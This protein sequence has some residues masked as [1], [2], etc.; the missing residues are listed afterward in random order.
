[1]LT[2]NP[3]VKYVGCRNTQEDLM[4]VV[5]ERPGQKPYSL[6]WR[7]DI[8]NHSP[9]GIGWGYP[10]SGAA[11]CAVAI[12]ADYFSDGENPKFQKRQWDDRSPDGPNE[13]ALQFYMDFKWAYISRLKMDEGF[14]LTGDQIDRII[15][16]L[17]KA[18]GKSEAQTT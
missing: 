5:V 13:L 15:I 7:L 18:Y 9:T 17:V 10:G 2:P 14:E 3:A 16:E 6:D 1:M 8:V 11:Q 4:E 12:L